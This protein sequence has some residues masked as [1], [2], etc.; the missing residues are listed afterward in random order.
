M[1]TV[2]KDILWSL[3]PFLLC[4]L[5]KVRGSNRFFT[6]WGEAGA[7]PH[8]ILPTWRKWYRPNSSFPPYLS[9]LLAISFLVSS[10]DNEPKKI[11]W[12]TTLIQKAESR[13]EQPC[14]RVWS[15]YCREEH[16]LATSDLGWIPTPLP[17]TDAAAP[18]L[19]QPARSL[20]RR[21]S[22]SEQPR[23]GKCLQLWAIGSAATQVGWKEGG[24]RSG[25]SGVSLKWGAG[26]CF[27][28]H[29]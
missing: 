10:R 15:C 23:L 28:G 14:N 19:C 9:P 13:E 5:G 25:W 16:V 3:L 22:H 1:T 29:A 24:V 11:L 27:Q 6:W 12:F 4:E 7:F 2:A 21:H 17:K 26:S 20:H 18:R 8:L